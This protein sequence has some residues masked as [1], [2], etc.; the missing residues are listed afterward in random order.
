MSILRASLAVAAIGVSA[1]TRA[2]ETSEATLLL[3]GEVITDGDYLDSPRKMLVVGERLVVLDRSPPMVHVFRASDGTRVGSFG[4]RGSGPSE[5]RSATTVQRDLRD[6]SSFW[7]YD[8]SLL[9]LSRLR[10]AEPDGLP[11]F[12][13]SVN[14]HS[15]AGVYLQPVWMTDSTLVVSG[16]YPAHPD[17][18]LIVTEPAGRPV[19]TI[20]AAPRH[21]GA[22]AI[23]TTVLQHAYEGP[24]V[25]HHGGSRLAV[26]TRLADRI[27]IY[28]TDGALLKEIAG[29]AGFLP[30]FEVSTRPEG[31][32]MATGEDLRVGYLDLAS[33]DDLIFA[34]FSGSLRSE[35]GSQV[36]SG[37]E[38]HVFDWSGERVATLELPDRA[39]AIAV[40]ARQGDLFAI[41]RDPAPR[42]VRYAL[43]AMLA[44]KAPRRLQSGPDRV[45]HRRQTPGPP[46]HNRG[47]SDGG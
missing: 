38:V 43:P 33:T 10:F 42:V 34:L 11:S 47:G 12:E 26:A 31:V 16:I 46:P 3:S 14:L 37:R 17:A 41:H 24:V 7:I 15:G 28:S 1:C 30:Q 8:L 19:A 25:V 36:Y 5:Y 2:P 20:G 44:A 29:A 13:G 4:A 9:R 35:A 23:P 40:D 6:P 39:P 45:E 32:S 18:R 27:E 22:A 21:P